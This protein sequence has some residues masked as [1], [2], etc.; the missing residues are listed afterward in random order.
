MLV[1]AATLGFARGEG[2]RAAD[3]ADGVDAATVSL[4]VATAA[5]VARGRLVSL[6]AVVEES[7]GWWAEGEGGL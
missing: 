2:S 6:R 4:V 1:A 3:A 7:K 5:A